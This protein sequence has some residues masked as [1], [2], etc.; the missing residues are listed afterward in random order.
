M[1]VQTLAVPIW[2]TCIGL[3]LYMV[4]VLGVPYLV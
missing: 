3:L 4:T 2:S 1:I